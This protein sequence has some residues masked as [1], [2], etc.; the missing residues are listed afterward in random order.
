MGEYSDE[1]VQKMDLSK[2]ADTVESSSDNEERQVESGEPGIVSN[3]VTSVVCSTKD[4]YE[5]TKS[6]L[7]QP[8]MK[9]KLETLESKISESTIVSSTGHMVE[10]ISGSVLTAADR[11]VAVGIDLYSQ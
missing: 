2:V 3:T 1:L 7:L 11:R 10:C 8:S 9:K 5:S 4:V 6:K